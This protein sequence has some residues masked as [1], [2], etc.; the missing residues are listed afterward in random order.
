MLGTYSPGNDSTFAWGLDLR[1]NQIALGMLHNPVNFPV[2]STW[3]GLNLLEWNLVLSRQAET[4]NDFNL[5]VF[6]NPGN[7][8]FSFRY[9]LESRSEASLSVFD[10]LGR[11]VWVQNSIDLDPGSKGMT[12]DLSCLSAG[13]YYCMITQGNHRGIT[14]LAKQE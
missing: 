7:D 3:G 5:S 2:A 8:I 10:A 9:T 14:K 6:P 1:G 4:V 13:I 12:V 11:P